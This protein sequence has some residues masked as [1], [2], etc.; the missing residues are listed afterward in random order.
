MGEYFFVA[1]EESGF[2]VGHLVVLAV[3]FDKDFCFF[4]VFAGHGG[5]EV[6]FDL[7]VEASEEVVFEVGGG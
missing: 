4:E 3:P 6:V 5:E 7:V 2:F 1:S